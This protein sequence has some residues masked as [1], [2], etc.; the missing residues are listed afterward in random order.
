M[1]LQKRMR[2]AATREP[3]SCGRVLADTCGS[4]TPAGRDWKAAVTH[5]PR[6]RLCCRSLSRSYLERDLL[7]EMVLN[8]HVPESFVHVLAAEAAVMAAADGEQAE[9][10]PRP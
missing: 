1:R 9:T 4:A 7:W 5:P 8:V 3:H 6:L 10:S 2:R